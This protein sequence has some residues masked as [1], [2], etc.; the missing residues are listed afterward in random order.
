MVAFTLPV[1]EQSVFLKGSQVEPALG[2]LRSKRGICDP[3]ILKSN[4]KYLQ[5]CWIHDNAGWKKKTAIILKSLTGYG[6]C[7]CWPDAGDEPLLLLLIPLYIQ[8]RQQDGRELLHRTPRRLVRLQNGKIHCRPK[9]ESRSSV[10]TH[11]VIYHRLHYR[12]SDQLLWPHSI[13]QTHKQ[14]YLKLG[15]QL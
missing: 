10:Q 8:E 4:A 2:S 15:K 6:T 13:C 12:V 1:E 3:H 9:Q 7:C 14:A 5:S 11:P